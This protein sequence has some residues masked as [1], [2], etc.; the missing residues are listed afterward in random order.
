MNKEMIMSIEEV[1]EPNLEFNIEE[2]M[3]K[4]NK[5]EQVFEFDLDLALPYIINY[6][7]N[8]TIKNLLLICKYYGLT[9]NKLNKEQIIEFLVHFELN[10]KNQE[11]VCKRKNM[12]FYVNELKNDN[13][14]K[15]FVI[16]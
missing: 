2:F 9:S 12:W 4:E 3:M 16:W 1:C 10:P 11:I 8:Y 13:F 5:S 15:N 14:M 7:E 6:R